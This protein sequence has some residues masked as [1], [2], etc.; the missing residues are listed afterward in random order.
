MVTAAD[1]SSVGVWDLE[2]GRKAMMLTECHGHE[3]ITSISFDTKFQ[4]LISGARD[5]TIKVK[6]II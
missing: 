6:H 4:R 5:G 3:E 1:D 2:T